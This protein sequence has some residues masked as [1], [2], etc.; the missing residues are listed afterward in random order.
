M[1]DP[2]RAWPN[3]RQ[4]TRWLAALALPCLLASVSWAQGIRCHVAYAGAQRTLNVQPTTRAND[5]QPQLQGASLAWVVVHKVAPFEEAVV[6]VSTYGVVGSEQRLL[7]QATYTPTVAGSSS[8]GFTGLQAVQPPNQAP[9]LRYW[10]ERS[11]Q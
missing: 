11:G 5:T 8:H 7:H 1:E 6:Q 2:T 10:C 3:R 4:H 9:E